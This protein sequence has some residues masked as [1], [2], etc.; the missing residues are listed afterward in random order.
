MKGSVKKI[1]FIYNFLRGFFYHESEGA[2]PQ[3]PL[4][5]AGS[6]AASDMPLCAMYIQN[7]RNFKLGP[8]PP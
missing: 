8:P 3:T 5:K 6:F 2:C 7:P 4:T 1:V